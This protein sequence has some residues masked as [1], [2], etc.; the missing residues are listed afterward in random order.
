MTY[1]TKY[2]KFT[3]AEAVLG[4]SCPGPDGLSVAFYRVACTWIK[5][6]VHGLIISFYTFSTLPNP[7]NATTIILIPRKSHAIL[8]INF[9]SISLTNI[10]YQIISKS[11]INSVG[12][13]LR[14]RRSF[15]KKHIR[16]ISV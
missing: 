1:S 11:L 7:L 15:K 14:C 12:D 4:L 2:T 5:N 10:P 9:R 13:L 3:G 8:V 6:D 16:K